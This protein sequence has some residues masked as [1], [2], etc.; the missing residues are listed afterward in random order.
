MESIANDYCLVESD[1]E[2]R[3]FKENFSIENEDRAKIQFKTLVNH[4]EKQSVKYQN[5]IDRSIEKGNQKIIPM[6]Q[7]KIAALRQRVERRKIEISEKMAKLNFDKDEICVG[8]I[9]I[10]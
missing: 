3:R 1:T 9:N 7:G 8:I 2:F 6:W 10:I 4:L 5:I